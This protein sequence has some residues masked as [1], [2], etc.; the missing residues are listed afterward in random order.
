MRPDKEAYQL[1]YEV[2]AMHSHDH[3]CNT[4]RP[5]IDLIADKVDSEYPLGEI[6]CGDARTTKALMYLLPQHRFILYGMP[7]I[8][9]S[10]QRNL[11]ENKYKYHFNET[12]KYTEYHYT[13]YHELIYSL[14]LLNFLEYRTVN[15]LLE[16]AKPYCSKMV[17]LVW[18]EKARELFDYPIKLEPMAS[19]ITNLNMKGMYCR[20]HEYYYIIG[21]EE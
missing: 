6:S 7:E 1:T 15:K 13:K 21:W 5:F 12:T 14:G 10:V 8:K 2:G 18:A 17:H 19:W 3:F 9:T 16:N 4:Y 20:N 11:K